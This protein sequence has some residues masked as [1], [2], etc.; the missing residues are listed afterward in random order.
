MTAPH[1]AVQRMAANMALAEQSLFATGEVKTQFIVMTPERVLR[2][3]TPW[4]DPDS[5]LIYYQLMGLF[6]HAEN[7]IAVTMIAEAWMKHTSLRPHE[8]KSEAI[9]RATAVPISRAADRREMLIVATAYRD[10]DDAI[11]TLL[12][13]REIVRDDTG[14]LSRT[15]PFN[16]GRA[17]PVDP[18]LERLL[19]PAALTPE[20]RLSARRDLTFA[21]VRSNVVL[22]PQIV[23]THSAGT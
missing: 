20:M 14:G 17:A 3:E 4:E 6:C 19:P 11:A 18:I 15:E 23:A 22:K 10:A 5:R 2:V 21:Q 1:P 8:T 7:A 16:L 9:K 13:A 12:E